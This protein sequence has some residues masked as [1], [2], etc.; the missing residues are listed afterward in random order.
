MERLIIDLFAELTSCCSRAQPGRLPQQ[1]SSLA[2]DG[3]RE[4]GYRSPS[5]PQ[6]KK[7]KKTCARTG[8]NFPNRQKKRTAVGVRLADRAACARARAPHAA[9]AIRRWESNEQTVRCMIGSAL[10]AGEPWNEQARSSSDLI[11]GAWLA[12]S[13]GAEQLELE[14]SVEL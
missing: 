7:K 11:H 8:E 6:K 10:G 12:F 13:L 4:R 14:R 1:R 5:P 3:E 9:G 2:G